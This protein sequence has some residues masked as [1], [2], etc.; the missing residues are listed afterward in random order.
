MNTNGK[1]QRL[2][3]LDVV[4]GIGILFVVIGHVYTEDGMFSRI[5]H[6]LNVPL[7]FLA[8]GYL[9]AYKREW[10]NE[11]REILDKKVYSILRPYF[12]FSAAM[13][14]WLLVRFFIFHYG[15]VK[16]ILHCLADIFCLEGISALW[17]LSA[18]L[19]G[20]IFFLFAE[21][22]IGKNKT[23]S[24]KLSVL[25]FL[26]F[27]IASFLAIN[28]VE[29]AENI[30][31]G[32][33]MKMIL[34]ASR[35]VTR[36][37]I[38]ATFML[39]GAISRQAEEKLMEKADLT[40]RTWIL[41]TILCVIPAITGLW[42]NGLR[43][44]HY[45]S[46]GC[47]PLYLLNG[48]LSFLAISFVARLGFGRRVLMVLG[49]NSLIIMGTHLIF[50]DFINIM[51]IVLSAPAGRYLGDELEAKMAT[52]IIMEFLLFWFRRKISHHIEQT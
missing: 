24:L 30:S 45:L 42:F 52:L 6:A 48:F 31:A 18:L 10:E 25:L 43:D 39:L 29:W 49:Q 36:G 41:G 32:V 16:E 3:W 26:G 1:K 9:S 40:K 37:A 27:S 35:I 12:L 4:K 11:K 34:K 47:F 44:F 14:A 21:Q 46:F 19:I 23:S 7:F 17:F 28:F 51:A 2:S 33:L 38:A 20:D 5:I 8:S 50:L 13:M 15:S 22:G